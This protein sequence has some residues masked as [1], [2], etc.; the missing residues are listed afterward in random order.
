MSTSSPVIL[1]PGR[2]KA[3]RQRHHWIFSGAIQKIPQSE[4]GEVLPVHAADGSFL[5]I[6]Y[7][8]RRSNIIGR[9]I[10]FESTS[11]LEVIHRKLEEAYELRKKFLDFSSTNAY[12][13]INGEGDG[14][15]GLILD[16]YD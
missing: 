2:E 7:F 9:M 11:L 13:L 4:D 14:I 1:K 5:G 16:V 8:N 10:S 15:P 3:L 12:R 6:G